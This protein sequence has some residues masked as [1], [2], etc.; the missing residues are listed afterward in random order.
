M[1]SSLFVKNKNTF[2][3][4]SF[5]LYLSHFSDYLLA[6]FLLPFIARTIG[7]VEFGKIGLAQTFG[8]SII[9]FMEFGSTLI[10]T[11]EVARIKERKTKLK[12]FIEEITTFKIFLI[13]IVIIISF[14]MIFLV[15]VFSSKP[16]YIFI[17]A[18]GSI[19]HGISPSWY[20]QGIEKM[21]KIA[22]SKLIFRLASF[23][24]IVLNIKSSNDGWII[25]A[26]FSLSSILICIYLYYELVKKI[27]HIKLVRFNKSKLILKKSIPSFLVTL[28]PMI[29][30]NISIVV[31]SFFINPIQLGLFFGASRIHRAFNSLY[32]P[33][34]LAFFPKI[35]LL[36]FRNKIKSE[37]VIKEYFILITTIGLIFFLTNYIFAENIISILLGNEFIESKKLLRLFS[38]ILPLTAISNALGR[39][40]MIAINKEFIFSIIQIISSL[41][42]LILLL[43][44]IDIFGVQSLPISLI[45]YEGMIIFL[46][47]IFL[48]YN[49]NG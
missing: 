18:L 34:S 46:I 23:L 42:A 29:Y 9:L 5:Y 11:R 15:P 7:A 22:L 43:F 31:L 16:H 6:L 8:L 24:I 36:N 40:W 28:V 45:F 30:Q 48:I 12:D 13:P 21:K 39:Q 3:N 27:G 41:I 14:F 49:P 4:N 37:K 10:A 44:L 47:L 25:L 32:S 1:N 26:S 38:F 2:I 35:S 33:I 17:V 20:F 19:F